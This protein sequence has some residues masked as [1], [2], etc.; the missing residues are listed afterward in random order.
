MLHSLIVFAFL[1]AASI[2]STQASPFYEW[3]QQQAKDYAKSLRESASKTSKGSGKEATL[4]RVKDAK[5]QKK[6]PVAIAELEMLTGQNPDDMILWLDL[7]LT[8][9][10]GAIEG[11]QGYYE[12]A[13]KAEK[14]AAYVY[15]MSQDKTQRALAIIVYAA[16]SKNAETEEKCLVELSTLIDIK[17]LRKDFP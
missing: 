4:A 15:F 14:A 5:A 8:A 16:I 12:A 7:A 6:W 13:N 1:V 10:R 9:Y 2:G 3:H 11:Q 17:T